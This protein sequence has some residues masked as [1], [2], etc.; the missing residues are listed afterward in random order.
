MQILKTLLN[1]EA[2]NFD[3]EFWKLKLDPPRIGTVSGKA[4]PFY[5]GGLSPDAREA[6]A[7]GS[8]V[9]L[10]WPDKAEAVQALIADMKERAAQH[11]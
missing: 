10:M 6:A 3:G 11:G 9:F 5:F 1:G 8:D 7:Q 4:P 2:L